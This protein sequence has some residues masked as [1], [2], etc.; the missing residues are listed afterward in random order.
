MS[1]ELLAWRKAAGTSLPY[2]N[3]VHNSLQ[4][5]GPE[6]GLAAYDPNNQL[7][8]L[9][10]QVVDSLKYTLADVNYMV[11]KIPV[12]GPILGPIVYVKLPSNHP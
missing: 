1:S 12:L 2:L 3:Q 5:L 4:P 7:E 9:I 6:K 10:K 8:T 11:Y